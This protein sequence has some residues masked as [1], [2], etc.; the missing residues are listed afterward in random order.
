MGWRFLLL[1]L[2][3]PIKQPE[4]SLLAQKPLRDTTLIPPDRLHKQHVNLESGKNQQG[5]RNA[6]RLKQG[7]MLLLLDL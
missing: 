1:A 4:V 2:Q 3:E 5:K 7:S 6:K